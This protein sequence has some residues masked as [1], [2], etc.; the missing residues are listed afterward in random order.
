[1]IAHILEDFFQ[2]ILAHGHGRILHVLVAVNAAGEQW[3][4]IPVE[5]S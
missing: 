5:S 3:L 4:L 2:A 1:M